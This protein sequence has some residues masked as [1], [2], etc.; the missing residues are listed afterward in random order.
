MA[1]LACGIRDH[2][3]TTQGCAVS[4]ASSPGDTAAL[5]ACCLATTAPHAEP[6]EFQRDC[7][8]WIAQN[9]YSTDYIKIKVGKRQRGSLSAVTQRGRSQ[10]YAALNTM[11]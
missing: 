2:K 8:P 9:D 6:F 11:V 7:A 10:S 4:A 3:V 1:A 5:E